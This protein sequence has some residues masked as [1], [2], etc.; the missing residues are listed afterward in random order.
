M[1]KKYRKKF[2]LD[3]PVEH[4]YYHDK[5]FT[6]KGSKSVENVKGSKSG[7]KRYRPRRAASSRAM[8]TVH[9]ALNSSEEV[10]VLIL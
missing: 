4:S 9:K 1:L 8:E 10:L 2:L 7:D 6:L 3:Q 5:D